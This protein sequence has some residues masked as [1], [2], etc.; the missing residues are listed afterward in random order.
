MKKKQQVK[1]VV[2]I[3]QGSNPDLLRVYD[4]PM[5]MVDF[6]NRFWMY[7]LGLLLENKRVAMV[8]LDKGMV[9]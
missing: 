7:S 9:P 1:K 2:W 6:K 4:L 8:T 3:V 5:T